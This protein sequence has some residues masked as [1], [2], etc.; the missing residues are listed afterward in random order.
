M[1]ADIPGTDCGS[2][3]HW[4]SRPPLRSPPLPSSIQ[5]AGGAS[6][7]RARAQFIGRAIARDKDGAPAL[8]ESESERNDS[9][10]TRRPRSQGR[11]TILPRVWPRSSS[12]NASRTS[13]SGKVAAIGTSNSPAAISRAISARTSAFSAA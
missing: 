3:E 6:A 11:S 7:I 2:A 4:R 10:T 1:C 13:P 5:P 9:S 12:W 8:S